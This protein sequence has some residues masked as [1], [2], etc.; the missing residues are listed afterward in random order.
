MIMGIG[1]NMKKLNSKFEFLRLNFRSR[2]LVLLLVICIPL[3]YSETA[4]ADEAYDAPNLLT[5]SPLSACTL[6]GYYIEGNSIKFLANSNLL[7]DK[8]QINLLQ[9]WIS[10]GV[11]TLGIYSDLNGGDGDLLGTFDVTTY[12]AGTSSGLATYVSNSP[13]RV[14]SGS[15]YWLKM[16]FNG[17]CVV[18][19]NL[20]FNGTALTLNLDG[21]RIIRRID[22]TVFDTN[23]SL[24]M[25]IFGRPSTTAPGAPNSVTATAT[26]KTT[27]SVSF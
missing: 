27:A 5:S 24:N 12:P 25:A 17:V 7:I 22:S 18:E 8:V 3:S 20:T 19:S 14:N 10:P 23:W 4:F 21:N 13:V 6:D 9:Y 2:A 15:Y 11:Q 26:G 16:N 1:S